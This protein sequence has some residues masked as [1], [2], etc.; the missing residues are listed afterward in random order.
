MRLH[1]QSRWLAAAVFGL[2]AVGRADVLPDDRT[3]LLYHLYEGG[4]LTVQGPS[5]L[6][7]K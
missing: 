5:V 4:G 3:D 2:G 7:R 6:V 1:L